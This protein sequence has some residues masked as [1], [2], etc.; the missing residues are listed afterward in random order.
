MST[1]KRFKATLEPL[2]GNLGW[3]I[4]RVPFDATK[5]WP[6]RNRM[7]VKGTIN[8]FAFRTSLFSM[9]DGTG[10]ILLVNKQMQKQGR[11]SRGETAEFTLEPD[12]DERISAMPPELATL[13]KQHRELKKFY[14]GFNPSMKTYIAK[15]VSEPKSAGS[16]IKRA[17]EL[18]ERMMLSI[19]GEQ[20]PPPILQLAFRRTPKAKAGWEAMTPV[21][22]RGHLM[23]IFYYKSPE[24]R[25]KRAQKAIE[26]ALQIA[27][28]RKSSPLGI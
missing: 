15:W 9:S 11:V 12:L 24:A 28:K 23:G 14:D 7:R 25:E 27:E 18:A 8:G 26:E 10:Q 2:R 19:E 22:R 3:T 6:E 13:F 1:L 5:V 17:E 16:R 4:A 21:Q 20:E